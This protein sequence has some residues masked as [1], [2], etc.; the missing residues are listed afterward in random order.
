VLFNKLLSIAGA[1][2]ASMSTYI[3]PVFALM[4][5]LLDG[6]QPEWFRVIGVLIILSGVYLVNKRKLVK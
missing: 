6:E 3:I 4:W 5:G 2:I 1:L